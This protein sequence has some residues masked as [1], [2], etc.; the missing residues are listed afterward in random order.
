MLTRE[1]LSRLPKAELHNHLDGSLRAQTLIE[2]AKDAGVPLP[3]RDAEEIRRYMLVDDARNL[4]EY[5]KRFDV[6]VAVLQR[7]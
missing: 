1:L 4:E 2:L 7:P 6:T 5:I 3:S